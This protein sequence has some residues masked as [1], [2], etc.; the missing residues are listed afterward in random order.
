ML[1]DV[2][3]YNQTRAT[4]SG[5]RASDANVRLQKMLAFTWRM[6]NPFGI[7]HVAVPG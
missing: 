5:H 2:F 1:L 6:S 7:V 3:R 4:G